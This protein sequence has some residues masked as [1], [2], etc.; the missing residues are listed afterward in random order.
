MM[1]GPRW[2][3]AGPRWAV[4]RLQALLAA[5][6]RLGGRCLT[7]AYLQNAS[8]LFIALDGILLISWEHR[9]TKVRV[10]CQMSPTLC[11]SSRKHGALV[12]PRNCNASS[13]L[14][15]RSVLK[16]KLSLFVGKRR[17]KTLSVPLK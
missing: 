9:E 3:A 17:E 13:W 11:A 15:R 16:V 1:G 2:E 5:S 4:P 10:E 8:F 6:Q 12:G 14:L 7:R